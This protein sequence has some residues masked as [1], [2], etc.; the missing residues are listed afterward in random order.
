MK[1]TPPRPESSGYLNKLSK[2]FMGKTSYPNLLGVVASLDGETSFLSLP[3]TGASSSRCGRY[4]GAGASAPQPFSWGSALLL[5]SP[6]FCACGVNECNFPPLPFLSKAYKNSH[7]CPPALW[8]VN[9]LYKGNLGSQ[10]EAS[11]TQQGS[12][13]F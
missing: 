5:F 8:V 2:L 7:I 1:D 4:R 12:N 3:V 10:Q 13:R 11:L 6:T 9:G